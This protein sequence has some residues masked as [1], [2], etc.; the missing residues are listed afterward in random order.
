MVVR[1]ARGRALTRSA[2]AS[3]RLAAIVAHSCLDGCCG[4]GRSAE[5]NPAYARASLE[6]RAATRGQTSLLMAEPWTVS[7]M[8][9][10]TASAI[11]RIAQ[12]G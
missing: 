5:R 7:A 10:T 11:I 9:T 6:V 3:N 4:V 8:M 1:D 2:T 12:I